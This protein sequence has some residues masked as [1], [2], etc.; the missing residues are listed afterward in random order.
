VSSE[1]LDFSLLP[2]ELRPLG[3]LIVKYAESDDVKRSELLAAAPADELQRLSLAAEP[4][5]DAINAYL[6][7][8]VAS[9]PG[10]AQDVA[11]ALDSFSQAALEARFELQSREQR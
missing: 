6:D 5:W 1:S 11:L 7:A 3:P 2:E 10:P 8:N 9:T 4:H